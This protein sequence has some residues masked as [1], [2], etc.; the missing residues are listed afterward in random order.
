MAVKR[1]A[2]NCYHFHS[3]AFKRY[4]I[5]TF[6]GY[7]KKVN[8]NRT[9][10]HFLTLTRSLIHTHQWLRIER[11]MYKGHFRVAVFSTTTFLV[12][13]QYRFVL[14]KNGKPGRFG[15]FSVELPEAIQRNVHVYGAYFRVVDRKGDRRH[16]A[17]IAFQIGE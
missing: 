16:N 8:R 9:L 3:N 11:E 6:V 12:I 15:S 5:E 17:I 1:L 14:E 2:Q 7:R 4:P 13:S 10:T